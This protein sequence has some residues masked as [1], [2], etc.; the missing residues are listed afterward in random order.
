MD[1]HLI[2]HL[3]PLGAGNLAQD[4]GAQGRGWEIGDD[5]TDSIPVGSPIIL[6]R[7][8]GYEA[9]VK[10][11]EIGWLDSVGVSERKDDVEDRYGEG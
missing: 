3:A 11:V 4:G 10:N 7:V 8:F 9:G 1:F 2:I 5:L 6:L